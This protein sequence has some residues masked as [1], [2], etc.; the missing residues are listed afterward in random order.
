[1][2][3]RQQFLK[4]TIFLHSTSLEGTNVKFTTSTEYLPNFQVIHKSEVYNNYVLYI[5]DN[6]NNIMLPVIRDDF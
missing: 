4:M 6:N 1:M 2:K 5:D 3:V